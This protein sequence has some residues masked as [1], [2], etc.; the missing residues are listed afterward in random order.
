M[1]GEDDLLREAKAG[2]PLALKRLLLAHGG[3]LRTR[4]AKGVP[5]RFRS[6]LAPE[7][8]LQET[9]AEAFRTMGSFEPEGKDAFYRWL[10]TIADHKLLDA[11]RSLKTAR[12]GGDRGPA[13]N[14]ARSSIANLVDVVAVTTRTPSRAARGHEMTAAVQV[15]LAGLRSEHRDALTLRYLQGLPIA[16]VAQKMGKTESAVHKICSRALQGLRKSMGEAADYA[17]RA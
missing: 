14:I 15:A 2:E 9:F 11:I 6:L 17:S 5:A 1:G 4:I 7:D 10:A 13:A 8:I 3:P 16:E 12:R